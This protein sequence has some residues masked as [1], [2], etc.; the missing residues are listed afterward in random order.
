VT[1]IETQV[2]AVRPHPV[3]LV[4]ADDLRRSRL[5]VFFRFLL[6]IPHYFWW[7]VWAFGAFFAVIANWFATLVSG[8]SP[9]GLHNFLAGF[10]RYS[11]HVF[12]YVFL[13]GNPFPAFLGHPGSYPVDVEIDPPERQNRWVTGFR[14]VL[15][16]PALTLVTAYGAVFGNYPAG[17]GIAAILTLLAW[18]AS[19]VLGRIPLGLRNGLVAATRYSAQACA[20]LFL[21]TDRYPDSD[22]TLPASAGTR[23]PG[24]IRLRATGDLRRS[25]L[26]VF[27]RLLLALPHLFWITLWGVLVLVLSIVA[28][29]VTLAMGRLPAGLH[30]FFAAFLRYDV[31]LTAFIFL[32][33]NPFPGFVGREGS[34]PVDL[35]I[36]PPERQHRLVTLFRGLLALPALIIASGLGWGLYVVGFLGWFVGLFLGR[37]PPGLERLGLWALRY[38]AET[39]GY[40]LLLTDRYPYS[41]P[42]VAQEP[43]DEQLAFEAA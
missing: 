41:G 5:T 8:R 39:Y 9:Q 20:Y 40:Y 32:V 12:A 35:E 26:T 22:P 36:D 43:Q 33:A 13:A 19:L 4:L 11:T 18:F 37:M 21:L 7:Q 28:W 42:P 34:Y 2:A 25:R 29:L 10:V 31:H 27:F 1:E 15:A 3:R 16:L 24:P 14:L 38:T 6:A 17:T 23:E 30:R